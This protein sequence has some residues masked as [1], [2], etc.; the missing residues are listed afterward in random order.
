MVFLECFTAVFYTER[1]GGE[2]FRE[3]RT[4]IVLSVTDFTLC[5]IFF[6]NVFMSAY[7][8][9]TNRV[10]TVRSAADSV[11]YRA[12]TAAAFANGA[13]MPLNTL[14]KKI[15]RL[16][17]R[18]DRMGSTVT[19]FTLQVAVTGTETVETDT[20]YRSVWIGCKSCIYDVS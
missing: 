20:V 12:V 11:W 9:L 5:R 15:I 4:S 8:A 17:C 6:S 3:D 7:P 2:H 13:G 18:I 16:M 19:R 14:C 1:T 10:H